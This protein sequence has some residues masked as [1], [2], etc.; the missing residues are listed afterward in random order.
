MAIPAFYQLMFPTLKHCQKAGD[1]GTTLPELETLLAHHFEL[2]KEELARLTKNG[3]KVFYGRLGW[4]KTYMK[5]AG[6]LENFEGTNRR[7]RITDR[8]IDF[9]NRHPSGFDYRD[10]VEFEE[11]RKFNPGAANVKTIKG[12]S[13]TD[14]TG[15]PSDIPH[16]AINESP[17]EAI[18]EAKDRLH[19]ALALELTNLVLK[20]TPA[21]FEKLVV[22]LVLAMGYGG[23]REEFGEVVGKS[24]DGGI[25]GIIKQDRLGLD[26][27]YIQA[28]RW[29]GTVGRQEIQA[30]VG[31]LEMHH[32]SKGIFITT[33]QFSREARDYVGVIGKRVVL[34]DGEDLANLMIEYKVGA[35]IKEKIEIKKVD[36]DY[37]EGE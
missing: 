13:T 34:V 31:S 37:F 36:L 26:S 8:G 5:M 22:D 18:L 32:A 9:L 30:F 2:S 28:K 3:G 17:D 11:Y 12:P 33:S 25:D 29:K 19:A 16:S 10:L 23:S 15:A 6:L 7:F 14:F 27:I 4:A 20:Q 24:H 21:F 35:T 1:K